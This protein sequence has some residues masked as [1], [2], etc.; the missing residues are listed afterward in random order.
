MASIAAVLD[1][2]GSPDPPAVLR[3]RS[4][5]FEI[6]AEGLV[7]SAGAGETPWRAVLAVEG[8]ETG[9][10][11][12]IDVGAL[13]WR[14]LP[15]TLGYQDTIPD[16]FNGHAGAVASGRIDAITRRPDGDIAYMDSE[17]VFTADEEGRKAAQ[18]V[19]DKK[20]RGVSID[21]SAVESRED[22]TIDTETGEVLSARLVLS[23]GKIMGAIVTAHQAFEEAI[24][25]VD[26]APLALAASGAEVLPPIDAGGVFTE[27][28]FAPVPFAAPQP[29]LVTPADS[30]GV[31]EVLG[32]IAL[33][34]AC[35]TGHPDRCRTPPN[36]ST[37]YKWF[38]TG[39][40]T[41]DDG[42]DLPVG[43]LTV[44]G[45]HA[46]LRM[47]AQEA[48]RHYDDLTMLAAFVRAGEDEYGIWIHGVLRS[49]IGDD[50]VRII[51][52]GV[53]SGD[54]RPIGGNL[55]MIGVH[56]VGTPGF[57]VPRALVA[58]ASYHEGE[59][60]ALIASGVPRALDCGD[61][62]DVTDRF[63]RMEDEIAELREENAAIRQTLAAIVRWTEVPV[64]IR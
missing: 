57:P 21:V 55:E 18:A 7:A 33:W 34:G 64:S 25:T 58:S 10:G 1:R 3:L 20:I 22:L 31:R 30:Y 52:A 54:W 15:L 24:I 32:H 45:T 4:V 46:P 51:Q 5:S 16:G 28:R 26:S 43:R 63:G 61:D 48:M 19:Y 36:S 13:E 12:F 39:S 14:D 35:H 38:H 50:E 6:V 42:T 27:A 56:Q 60:T 47:N 40:V 41:L 62:E 23:R 11:R 53:P 29:L 9:D 44:G 37:D 49:D 2:S 59:L 17:G 8:V